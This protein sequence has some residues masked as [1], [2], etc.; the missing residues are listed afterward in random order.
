MKRH[1]DTRDKRKA[2]ALLEDRLSGTDIVA[3][4]VRLCAMNLCLHGIG[5]A[6]SPVT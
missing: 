6:T 1:P 3:E 2:K 4:I 5:G